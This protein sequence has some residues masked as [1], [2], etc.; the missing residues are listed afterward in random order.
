MIDDVDFPADKLNVSATHVLGAAKVPKG[1]NKFSPLP[2]VINDAAGAD[3]VR[4]KVGEEGAGD[5]DVGV[6]LVFLV[7]DLQAVGADGVSAYAGE[8][9]LWDDLGF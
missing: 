2:W 6:T 3:G 5:A 4:D 9:F 8:F 1:P 7:L